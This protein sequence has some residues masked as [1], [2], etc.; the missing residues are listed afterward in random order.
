MTVSIV[1]MV[2]SVIPMVVSIIPIISTSALPIASAS[3][4]SLPIAV[5]WSVAEAHVLVST[6]EAKR[7]FPDSKLNVNA[8]QE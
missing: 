2:I 4:L 1:P 5:L 6:G 3:L 7:T 8:M